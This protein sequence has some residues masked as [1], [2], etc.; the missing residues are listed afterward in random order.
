M[1]NDTEEP[2]Y[3][4]AQRRNSEVRQAQQDA[5]EAIMA[6]KASRVRGQMTKAKSSQDMPEVLRETTKLWR[7]SLNTKW[8]G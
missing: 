1:V 3:H 8:A 5:E 2:A 6:Q 4:F 7:G